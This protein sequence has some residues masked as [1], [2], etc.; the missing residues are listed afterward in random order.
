MEL[1]EELRSSNEGEEAGDSQSKLFDLE[2]DMDAL[3]EKRV[4]EI[5]E[6]L[7][8]RTIAKQ[9]VYLNEVRVKTNQFGISSVNDHDCFLKKLTRLQK[10]KEAHAVALLA[11]KMK[12]E[13]EVA[14][15]T[16]EQEEINK[17][18]DVDE[19]FRQIT[20]VNQEC[21]ELYLDDVMKDA[22][23]WVADNNAQQ[24]VQ[25]LADKI[26]AMEEYIK[27]RLA[28]CLMYVY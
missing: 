17:R 9:L 25:E 11:E 28:A 26:D 7:E 6:A 19:I 3:R 27:E 16:K 13:K 18:R 10:E 21:I 12:I 15:M 8:G 2:K 20:K 22:I 14:R 23:E 24:Y 1:V 4:N 5:M